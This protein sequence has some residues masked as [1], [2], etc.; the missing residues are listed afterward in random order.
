[1]GLKIALVMF[2][3]MGVMTGGFYWYYHDSQAKMATLHKNAA[4]LE[5]AVAT[6]EQAI[7]QLNNDI[8]LTSKITEETNRELI[9]ARKQVGVIQHKFNKTSKLLG[10][11]NIGRLALAKPKLI[12]KIINNGSTDVFRCFEIISGSSLTEKEVNVEKKS[13]AN[14]SCPSVANPNYILPN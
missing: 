14:T 13:K 8:K 11:R 2:I 12:Q 1:V 5:T 10:E 9:A 7:E 4:K 6:Q 3:I